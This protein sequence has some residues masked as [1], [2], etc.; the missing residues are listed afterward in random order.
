[1]GLTLAAR[2]AGIAAGSAVA[3]GARAAG[4]PRAGGSRGRSDTARVHV[5]REAP[6]GILAA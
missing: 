2:A 6:L 3:Y 1:M 5:H 4:G